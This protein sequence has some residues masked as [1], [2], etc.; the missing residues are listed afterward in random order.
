MVID[1]NEVQ[2]R[3]LEQVRQVVAGTQVLEFR[4]AESD[5]KLIPES[6]KTL[7]RPPIRRQTSG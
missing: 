7:A 5:A 4:Q 6:E 1:M 3:A 2:V